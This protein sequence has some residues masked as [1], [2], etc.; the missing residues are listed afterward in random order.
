MIQN[1]DGTFSDPPKSNKQ[2]F[3]EI[4]NNLIDIIKI[5][6]RF[7]IKLHLISNLFLW[8]IEKTQVK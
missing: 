5:F 3:D 6:I 7:L 2:L 4:R 1:K 8:M